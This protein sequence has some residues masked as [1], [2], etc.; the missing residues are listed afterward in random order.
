MVLSYLDEREKQKEGGQREII[1]CD[2]QTAGVTH[3]L[4]GLSREVEDRRGV[5]LIRDSAGALR[6]MQAVRA[7]DRSK[8]AVALV[9]HWNHKQSVSTHAMADPMGTTA[10]ADCACTCQ[11]RR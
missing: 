5:V 6:A 2:M 3:G 11:G 4:V 9:E 8:V 1:G 10:M 7:R